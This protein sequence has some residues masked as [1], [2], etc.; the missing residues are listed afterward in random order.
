MGAA[1]RGAR[2]DDPL[3]EVTRTYSSE[4]LEL[5]QRALVLA[6]YVS[7]PLLGAIVAAG[8]AIS[9]VQAALKQSDAT[10]AVAPRIL[11]AGGAL[12]IFGGWMMAILGGFCRELWAH[13]P[14]IVR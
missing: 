3:T 11:A 14:E 10:V 13:L 7:L 2:A 12:L 1:Y 4:L 5:A 6:L 8:I 9:A